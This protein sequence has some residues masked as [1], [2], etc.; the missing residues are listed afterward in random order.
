MGDEMPA[1]IEW[2]NDQQTIMLIQI[3]GAWVFDEVWA[4]Y[5]KALDQIRVVEHQVHV[6]IDHTRETEQPD[7]MG[8]LVPKFG[9]LDYP[10]NIGLIIQV[11]SRGSVRTGQELYSM[12]YRKVHNVEMMEDAYAM[13]K[14]YDERKS[15]TA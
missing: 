11:G 5:V 1:T 10:P 15:A 14:V 6:I 9:E 7:N 3:D 13:I 8:A 4:A 2:A 12:I